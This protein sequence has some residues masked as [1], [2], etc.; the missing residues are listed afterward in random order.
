MMFDDFAG[1]WF[2]WPFFNNNGGKD[3]YSIHFVGICWLLCGMIV[4]KNSGFL[5]AFDKVQHG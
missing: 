5:P 4:V 3:C 2:W 1:T